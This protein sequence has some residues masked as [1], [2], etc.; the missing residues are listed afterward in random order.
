MSNY[1]YSPESSGVKTYWEED[2]AARKCKIY[3]KNALLFQFNLPTNASSIPPGYGCIPNASGLYKDAV[4]HRGNLQWDAGTKKRYQIRVR[5]CHDQTY[6]SGSWSGS[7]SFLPSGWPLP[8]GGSG[9]GGGGG[10]GGGVGGG[11]GG[12]STV[13]SGGGDANIAC[14]ALRK[15]LGMTFKKVPIALQQMRATIINNCNDMIQDM[16]RYAFEE[17]AEIVQVC[18]ALG[19]KRAY[20][21][22]LTYN[23]NSEEDIDKYIHRFNLN[24]ALPFQDQSVPSPN[25]GRFA[26]KAFFFGTR[27][28]IILQAIRIDGEP[29]LVVDG[30][31][32]KTVEDQKLPLTAFI[33]KYRPEGDSVNP[34]MPWLPYMTCDLLY[35]IPNPDECITTIDISS[36]ATN[37]PDLNMLVPIGDN[38]APY[39]GPNKGFPY[40]KEVNPEPKPLRL[41]MDGSPVEGEKVIL[42]NR[43]EL[44]GIV[45]VSA[46]E[47]VVVNIQNKEGGD[48]GSTIEVLDSPWDLED[49]DTIILDPTTVDANTANNNWDFIFE[50]PDGEPSDGG[51][52]I[53]EPPTGRDPEDGPDI[54]PEG[55]RKDP[56]DDGEPTPPGGPGDVDDDIPK[57]DYDDEWD[58]E[59]G[60]GGG[61]D[62]LE[63][64]IKNEN[65][66]ATSDRELPKAEEDPTD[67]DDPGA[68]VGR[69]SL[70]ASYAGKA[71]LQR[72]P[73]TGFESK[74]LTELNPGDIVE[75][76]F[77]EMIVPGIFYSIGH[78]FIHYKG[79]YFQKSYK[80]NMHIVFGNVQYEVTGQSGGG[81]LTYKGYTFEYDNVYSVNRL[82][83]QFRP[84]TYGS[85]KAETFAQL[86]TKASLYPM[87][88]NVKLGYIVFEPGGSVDI[89]KNRSDGSDPALDYFEKGDLISLGGI[90]YRFQNIYNG[91]L[92]GVYRVDGSDI[93]GGVENSTLVRAAKVTRAMAQNEYSQA[94]ILPYRSYYEVNQ[95][96]S[97]T[98]MTFIPNFSMGTNYEGKLYRVGFNIRSTSSSPDLRN[99]GF[100]ERGYAQF[101][102]D[103]SAT[104]NSRNFYLPEASTNAAIIYK[105]NEI[106]SDGGFGGASVQ[107]VVSVDSALRG[108]FFNHVF[109]GPNHLKH[110]KGAVVFPGDYDLRIDEE[111][112]GELYFSNGDDRYIILETMKDNHPISHG[113]SAGD[114]LTIQRVKY[115]PDFFTDEPYGKLIRYTDPK[116]VSAPMQQADYKD[117]GML[118]EVADIVNP[119]RFKVLK[120]GPSCGSNAAKFFHDYDKDADYY[121][122]ATNGGILEFWAKYFN[123][124]FMDGTVTADSENEYLTYNPTRTFNLCSKGTN[125]NKLK[126]NYKMDA[127]TASYKLGMTAVNLTMS[128]NK[129]FL[130]PSTSTADGTYIFSIKDSVTAP[131]R[132]LDVFPLRVVEFEVVDTNPVNQEVYYLG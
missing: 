22:G 19:I 34:F 27:N 57:T 85:A 31:D 130:N 45:K 62:K 98:S 9:S 112:K 103:G 89:S 126:Y 3:F 117:C 69:R 73:I 20:L 101:L 40:S 49:G 120:K 68:V 65:G 76:Q 119:H 30:E 105:N 110:T 18:T 99:S 53:P 81:T 36:Q 80:K 33:P 86:S 100:S 50:N 88:N 7:G 60:G 35:N 70:P 72:D 17:I 92:R 12:G 125:S 83:E 48:T 93:G 82:K 29:F 84:E 97:D 87:M 6:L 128:G 58:G 131:P 115:N 91:Q 108:K 107:G 13:G 106:N 52:G 129:V 111:E 15:S 25:G 11:T 75:L 43:F 14:M 118:I 114:R 46:G 74:Y 124:V 4:A 24:G 95:I 94:M 127:F 122:T 96:H 79:T 71:I 104:D 66:Q 132:L 78:G 51:D 1:Y 67:D 47:E 8:A 23:V 90:E 39:T 123:A 63:F 121:L 41:V 116:F 38:P 59:G 55:P 28:T 44:S 42:A 2:W 21:R 16:K 113:F 10:G 64:P 5:S 54:P 56:E 26:D 102:P 109:H 61:Q 32:I 37:P 77:E